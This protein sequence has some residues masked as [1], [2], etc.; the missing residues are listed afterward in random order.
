MSRRAPV[1]A[2]YF[3]AFSL[4]CT[5]VPAGCGSGRPETVP[6]TG[7][8]TLDGKALE[9]ASVLLSPEAGGH[10]AT[11]LTDKDGRF[12]LTTFVKGDGALLGKHQVCVVKKKTS[13]LL[14]DADGLSGGTA[15]GGVS[16]EWLAPKKYANPK[17]S[18]LSAEVKPGMEPLEF[19]LSAR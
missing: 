14:T 1:P 6:V 18:G 3:V 15:P 9:A 17:T 10:P 16:E 2:W 11:G 5:I 7:V 8:V 19:R 13:G 4:C 12:T